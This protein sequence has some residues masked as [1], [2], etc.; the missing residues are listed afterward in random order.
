MSNVSHVAVREPKQ[1]SVNVWGDDQVAIVKFE[2]SEETATQIVELSKLAAA[3][4]LT[5]VSRTSWL[6]TYYED[7]EETEVRTEAPELVVSKEG[8]YFQAM[9]RHDDVMI[10]SEEQPIADLVAHFEVEEAPSP[11]SKIQAAFADITVGYEKGL[12]DAMESVVLAL[13]DGVLRSKLNAAIDTVLDAC[14]NNDQLAEVNEPDD[15]LGRV[16]ALRDLGFAVAIWTPDE[17]HEGVDI[18]VLQDLMVERGSSYIDSTRLL[19]PFVVVLREDDLH[20]IK[21]ACQAED[22]EHA[23]EQAENAYPAAT[24]LSVV[25]A[26][27]EAAGATGTN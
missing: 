27:L 15:P 23:Q 20:S 17:L 21:F 16:Q 7:D 11:M 25:E 1:Y 9:L 14:A 24:V 18:S 3:L 6:T 10:Q 5:G 2:I 22:P 12:R 13:G 26:D 8:F 19:S 4:D